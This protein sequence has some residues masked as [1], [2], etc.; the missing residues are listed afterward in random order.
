MK[1]LI[2]SQYFW[3]ENFRINDL[4]KELNKK[5][6][7]IDILTGQPN[8]PNGEFYKGYNFSFSTEKK[9]NLNIMRVP[10]I[11]RGKNYITLFLNYVSFAFIASFFVLFKKKKYDRILAINYSPI[12]SVIPAIIAK[13]KNKAKLFLWVQD[14]WPESFNAVVKKDFF[15]LTNL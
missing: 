11:P 15:G 13:K 3:P 8:Y 1:I 12:T 2:V 6:Y 14:L 4:A 10:I 5:G 7:N 9:F